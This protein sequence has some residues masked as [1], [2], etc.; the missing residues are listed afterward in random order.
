MSSFELTDRESPDGDAGEVQ[1]S[2]V[3]GRMRPQVGE[4]APLHDP[5]QRLIVA[6]LGA[7][8]AFGPHVRALQRLLVVGPVMRLGALVEHHD[9]IR[10]EVLL[11]GDDQLGREAVRRTVEVRLEGDTVVVDLATVG[12]REDLEAAEVREQRA[13]PGHEGVQAAALRHAACPGAQ[14]KMVGVGQHQAGAEGPELIG[15]DGLDGGLRADGSEDRRMQ[16]AVRGVENS[17]AAATIAA[18]QVKGERHHASQ[19]PE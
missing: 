12:E 9:D 11:G 2:D 18:H 10:P 1:G 6:P 4:D 7:Q 15:R 19:V 5:E 16:V 13:V 14:V 8:A 3:S 17:G